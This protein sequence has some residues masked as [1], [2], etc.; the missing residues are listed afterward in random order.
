M[1]TLCSAIFDGRPSLPRRPCFPPKAVFGGVRAGLVVSRQ[2]GLGGFSIRRVEQVEVCF[3]GCFR[4]PCFCPLY[5]D[6]TRAASASGSWLLSPILRA[7]FSVF[8]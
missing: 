3:P 5:S 4:C 6:A 7:P 8:E 2:H 1:P